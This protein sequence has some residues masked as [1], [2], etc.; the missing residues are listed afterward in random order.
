MKQTLLALLLAVVAFPVHGADTTPMS[1]TPKPP[2]PKAADVKPPDK[3]SPA[4]QKVRDVD[5]AKVKFMSA[6]GACPKAEDCDPES[7]RRNKDLVEMLK[8]GE[9][10]FMEACVQCATDKACEQE[11][12]RIRAGKGRMGYNVCQPPGTKPKGME[13]GKKST[14]ATPK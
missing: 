4:Q 8:H 10:A 14:P 12:D 2:K 6:V 9:D 13:S 5:V 1:S 3:V 7:P 11:R